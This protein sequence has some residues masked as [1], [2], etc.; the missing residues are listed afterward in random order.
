MD[1]LLPPARKLPANSGRTLRSPRLR[2]ARETLRRL[3][4]AQLARVGGGLEPD[5]GGG[6]DATPR[7]LVNCPLPDAVVVPSR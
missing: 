7:S 1:K 5:C 6:G 2:L 4:D 3:D